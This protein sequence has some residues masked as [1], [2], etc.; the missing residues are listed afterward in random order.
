MADYANTKA[1]VGAVDQKN[2]VDAAWARYEPL[3]DAQD[4]RDTHLWGVSL[5][6]AQ[7]GQVMSDDLLEVAIR[8]AVPV[9][10]KEAR[11]TVAPTQYDER[12]EFD[13]NEYQML[14]FMQLDQRPVSSVES[15]RVTTAND[16]D[17]WTVDLSWID[18]GYLRRGQIYI[19]P[20]NVAIAPSRAAGNPAG[21]AAF[22]AILGQLSYVPGYWRV[23]YT[24]GFPDMRVPGNVNELIGIQAAID[25]LNRLAQSNART[26]SQ[27]IG[28]DGASQGSSGPGPQIY[29]QAIA[30]LKEK[31]AMLLGRV[32]TDFGTKLFTATL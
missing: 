22:L 2:A 4:L 7:T 25:V 16:Q 20:I 23:T 13:R 3:L 30:E 32:R 5:R 21:G 29:A 11:I 1:A 8:R 9:V 10:E 14:G 31:K 12:R 6:S 19:L 28:L 26:T 24:A 15:L 17:I 27:S 18:T